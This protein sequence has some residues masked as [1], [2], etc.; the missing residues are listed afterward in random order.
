M[1]GKTLRIRLFTL[2]LTALVSAVLWA[3]TLE[4]ASRAAAK[5][6]KATVISAQ[7]VTEGSKKVHV[8]KLLT[9]DGVVKTVRV[10]AR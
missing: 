5:K 4:E 8:I 1:M 10:P 6:Y 2:V 7:T 3:Q 9:E